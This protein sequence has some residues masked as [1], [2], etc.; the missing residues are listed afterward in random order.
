MLRIVLIIVGV[1]ILANMVR[2]AFIAARDES[3]PQPKRRKPRAKG[4]EGPDTIV[5]GACGISFD[6]DASGWICPRCGK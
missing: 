1:L 3:A 4:G 5:C 6:P 2:R